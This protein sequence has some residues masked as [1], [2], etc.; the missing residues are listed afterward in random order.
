M[1]LKRPY[2][3]KQDNSE[4][5]SIEGWSIKSTGCFHHSFEKFYNAKGNRK[6]QHKN[7]LNQSIPFILFIDTF[8]VY[9]RVL[10]ATRD[11]KRR[12]RGGI[13]YLALFG[14]CDTHLKT[15]NNLSF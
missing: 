9:P 13:I 8:T 14:R 15:L 11:T 4:G 7:G 5:K 3:I 12:K 6:D 2:V 10:L 1:G